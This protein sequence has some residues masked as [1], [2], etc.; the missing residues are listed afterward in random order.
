L[1][2]EI[3]IIL[4]SLI[5][6]KLKIYL[7]TSIINFITA[8]DA[9]GQRDLTIEFFNNYIK[10]GK[11]EVYISP[12]FINEIEKTKDERRRQVL[13]ETI[14]KY[15]I[16]IIDIEPIIDEV[17]RLASLYIEKHIILKSKL[18]DALH[19]AITTVCE[20]DIL[21]SWNFRDLANI[22]KEMH[23]HAINITEGYIKDFRM[24]TPM[25]VI[26]DDE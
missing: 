26:S 9:L 18:E 16:D 7:D 24:I 12:L 22:N 8:D 5:L 3:R 4:G 2:N 17:Q 13:L 6:K 19:I 21:L 20:I 25:E 11:Y 14:K 1:Y 15:P 23:I 10:Q